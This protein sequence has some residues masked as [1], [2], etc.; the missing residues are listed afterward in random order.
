[1]PPAVMAGEFDHR[2]TLLNQE[3][4]R[5]KK[6]ILESAP[7][8]NT[9]SRIDSLFLKDLCRYRGA[10][11][12][13]AR[14]PG[15]VRAPT[16]KLRSSDL[17]R[18]GLTTRKARNPQ[19]AQFESESAAIVTWLWKNSKA[20]PRPFAALVGIKAHSNVRGPQDWSLSPH[21]FL[22]EQRLS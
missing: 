14:K 20:E 18:I 19:K 17:Q 15:Q 21:Y 7:C 16:P 4:D 5:K 3:S 13:P 22:S 9:G 6:K 1:M 12:E 11:V 2:R 10:Q 8:A